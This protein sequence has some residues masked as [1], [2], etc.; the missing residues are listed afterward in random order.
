[1]PLNRLTPL[2]IVTFNAIPILGLLLWGWHSFDII[3]LYW[4]ENVLIGVITLLRMVVRPYRQP[5]EMALSAFLGPFFVFHYGM[6][7]SVHGFFVVSLFA[8]RELSGPDLIAA[9]TAAPDLLASNYLWLALLGLAAL[10]CFDWVRD[11]LQRGLG[12]EDIQQIMFAPYQRIV[13][14]HITIMASAFALALLQAPLTG[15]LLLVAIKTAFDFH[16]F[17][18]EQTATND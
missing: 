8:D 11:S 2:A 13:V 14:L 3:Y 9:Y 12:A 18:K 1:M 10:H 15:V 5:S 17:R 4:L 6:F 7:C 16:Y